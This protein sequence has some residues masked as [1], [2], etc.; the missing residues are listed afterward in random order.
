[1]IGL[2]SEDDVFSSEENMKWKKRANE[3]E[4]LIEEG[5][6]KLKE[7]EDFSPVL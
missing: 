3:I 2:K 6:I 7:S 5:F 4:D 1:M